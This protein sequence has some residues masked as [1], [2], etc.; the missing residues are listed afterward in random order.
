M[1]AERSVPPERRL[2][3]AM[4]IGEIPWGWLLVVVLFAR[5]HLEAQDAATPEEAVDVEDLLDRLA[6]AVDLP[7][8]KARGRRA[9]ELAADKAI[10]LD[11]WLGAMERFGP[12][13]LEDDGGGV[14]TFVETLRP[15]GKAEETEILVHLPRDYDH[16]TPHPMVVVLHGAGGSGLGSMNAYRAWSDRLG[17]ICICPTEAGSNQGYTGQP[18]ERHSVLETVRW[19]R[20]RYHVDPNRV[21]VMG[22]SRG[23]HLTW[24]LILRFPDLWAGAIPCAGAPRL[25][26]TGGRNN[27]RYASNVAHM[28]IRALVGEHEHPGMHRN[29]REVFR[30][31]EER[32]A[33]KAKLVVQRGH[34]HSFDI[35]AVNGPGF[36]GESRRNPLQPRVVRRFVRED[37]ARS[38]WLEVVRAKPRGVKE[39][40]SVTM[41]KGFRGTPTDEQILT[42]VMEQADD[43]TV[44]VVGHYDGPGSIR[45][46]RDGVKKVR[47][48][49]SRE[50]LDERGRITVMD[51]KKPVK[52]RPKPSKRV[53][54]EEFVE[55][56]DPSFLPISTLEL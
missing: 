21:F 38:H 14:Q 50:M 36:F 3:P 43:R 42:W 23:G 47:L 32:D 28:A 17:L 5:P 6:E 22:W 46:E 13:E 29:L 39:E 30:R 16:A 37:E 19:A 45:I 53:L 55:R 24:D 33:L 9:R 2:L 40:W 54:L 7:N 44:E 56:F 26:V 8:A 41:P 18:R 34:G 12:H 48:Y 27:M 52:R 10:E 15:L 51:G 25:P 20:R 4:R 31:L 35:Q 1:V 49:L 11:D